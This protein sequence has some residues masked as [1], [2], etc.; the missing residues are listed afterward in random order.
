VWRNRQVQALREREEWFRTVANDTPAYLWMS[1]ADAQSSFLN[2]PMAKF[3]GIPDQQLDADWALTI[4]PE[5]REK[6]R[7]LYLECLAARREYVNEFRVRRSDGEYRWVI[8]QGI[9]RFSD[10]GEFLGYAGSLADITE[11]RDAEA[12]LRQTNTVLAAELQERIKA[13]HEVHDLSARL[14]HAQEEERSRL[15]RELH[16]DLSQQIA[17]LNLGVFK[18]KGKVPTESEARVEVDKIQ[19]KLVE[20]AE[21][22]R[23]LS[24]ELHP[25][26]LKHAGLATALQSYCEELAALAS[27]EI[28]FASGDGCDVLPLE[29]SL[30]VYR[31]AQEGLQN[32]I[33]HSQANKA[34]V[35]L[36]NQDGAIHLTVSDHGVGI[37]PAAAGGLGLVSIKERTRL[38]NGTVEVVSR[39]GEGVTL[40]LRVPIP[41][42]ERAKI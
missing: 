7:D 14:I 3:F 2:K 18:L 31:V 28:T 20:L 35:T 5:D 26:V 34:E 6:D 24:H 12:Q 40:R 13:E 17:A 9:P 8:A 41:R 36:K 4:H 39:P 29:A 33:K 21:H 32:F 15:A 30:C 23:R 22:T 16:D 25:G 19:R 38:V 1:T 10:Q 42:A 37:S 11:R 27:R